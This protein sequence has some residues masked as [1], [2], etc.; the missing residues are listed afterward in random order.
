MEEQKNKSKKVEMHPN[1]GDSN[2][3]NQL[4]L[5]YEQLKELADRLWSENRYLKQQLQQATEF[6]NTISRLDYLLRIIEITHNN[7]NNSVSFAPEFAE[8]CIAEVQRIMTAPE[9][10]Q[11]S[12]EKKED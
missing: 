1:A 4:K 6:A 7:K 2:Q 11:S 12:E 10:E 9:K 3:D 5:T 8:Q